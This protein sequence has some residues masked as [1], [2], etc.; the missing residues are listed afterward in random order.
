MKM[1]LKIARKELQLLFYSPVAWFLLVVFAI[2]TGLVFVGK[3]EMFL[4]NREYGD[5][6]QF[7]ASASVFMRGLWGIVSGYLYYYIPLLT[8]GLV[9]RELSSGSI[10]LLYSSPLTNA[11]IILGKFCSMVI[12][13][14]VMC[15]ILLLY[16]FVGWGT[17]QDF[18]LPAILVGLLGLFLLTCTYAAVG[19]FVSSLTSYQ[20]V[21][22]VGTFIVLMFLSMIGGWW[23]EYDFVREVT[24]WLSINGRASTFIMGMICSED[25]LYFPI[26]T[27]LFLSLTIIRLVA[28]RQKVRFAITLG[29]NLGV[30]LVV[31]LLGYFSSRPKLMAYYDASSTKWN[32]L[33]ETSQEVIAKMDGDVKI[34]AYVNILDNLYAYYAYPNFIMRNREVFKLYERFKPETKLKVVYYYDSITPADGGEACNSFVALCEKNPGKTLRELAIEKCERW[35]IDSAKVKTPEEVREMTDL[36]GEKTFVW[37]IVR[38]NGKRTF[39]RTYRKDPMSPF[40]KETEMTAA[41]KRL[42]MK[43]P[44]VAFVK[45][46]GMRTISDISPR[47]YNTVAGDRDFRQSLINQGFDAVEL[48]LDE[49]VPEDV[50]ILTMADVRHPLTPEEE[51]NL[52]DFVNKGGNVF[53]LGEPKRREVMNP[54]LKKLFGV[55]LTEG[56]LV[57]YR[58]D[59]LQPDA[60]YSLM[61]EE[62][63]KLTFYYEMAW[64]VMMPTTAGLRKVED[65]GF[66]IIPLLKSDTVVGEV[67]KK[68]A[69][70][71]RVWNEMES[72]DYRDKSLKY[73]QKAGEIAGDYYPALILTRNVNG[74]E[75]RIVLT[76]DADC[77]SNSEIVA[78]RAPAN[79]VMDLG[80]YHYLSYLEMP[81]DARRPSST[82]TE[83]HIDRVGF[84]IIRIGFIYVLPLLFLGTGVFLW[85]R[86]KGR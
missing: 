83:V 43:L 46:Y 34:T 7:M 2:Q 33:T 73:N 36:T 28:V 21:A 62:A 53:L 17:I 47:G 61:S 70:S 8:M 32:T 4:K 69:R 12:Y 84:N 25:L 80:T 58:W 30:I 39:L 48:L 74:K 5:W 49:P 66:N 6:V 15:L 51:K 29:R 44:K 24:Y 63:K 79:F 76:G 86:R 65:K 67:K 50:D 10:K 72:L 23:Q 56:T 85:V 18:E 35:K 20:F 9:S 64:Y 82:D 71:Y 81:I 38:K 75:Q 19:I 31:C 11:Q 52:T 41:F 55:E 57:Q 37:E 40:P 3:Y 42:T 54:F 77:I 13:A 78:S 68:E 16:V 27:A 45:G 26:V 14:G 60:L 22:A 59:W 1:I